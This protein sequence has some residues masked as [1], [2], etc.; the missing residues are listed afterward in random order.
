MH[1]RICQLLIAQYDVLE[2]IKNGIEEELWSRRTFHRRGA[3]YRLSGAHE[4]SQVTNGKHVVID[5]NETC[6]NN[7]YVGR[8]K[9]MLTAYF[10][11][12]S[13][14]LRQ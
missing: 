14:I 7:V 10:S 12:R 3:M 6:I 8:T 2:S 5:E 13:I 1:E 9:R 11:S 4:L